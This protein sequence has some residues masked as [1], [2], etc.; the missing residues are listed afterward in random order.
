MA[1]NAL[2]RFL[3]ARREAIGPADVGLPAGERRRTPGLRRAELAALAGVSVEYLTRLERGSD[4][5]PS[6]QV[7][8]ALADAL[9]LTP[10]ERV[11]LQ[12][13][14]KAASGGPCPSSVP[15]VRTVRPT[16]RALLERLDPAPAFVADPWGDVLAHTEG[17]GLLAGPLGLLDADPPNI[18]RYVFTD[19]RARE[20][21]PEWE[22]VADERA[23]ALR[24]AADL[25][26]AAVAVFADELSITAGGEFARRFAASAVLPAWTGVERWLHPVAGPLRLA[27]ESLALPGT[28]EHR[29]VVHLPADAATADALGALGALGAER[30]TGTVVRC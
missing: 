13:L 14:V 27:F 3:R 9:D 19:A 22:R 26:D 30:G 25:G 10:D 21:F 4:R 23:A 6:G 12:R 29:L 5:H 2:G 24:A 20:A 8:G 17:F 28:E 15:A 11:H 1:D 16:V 18:H 7:L